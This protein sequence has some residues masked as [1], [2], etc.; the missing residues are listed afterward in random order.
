VSVLRK[1]IAA[2]GV[3]TAVGLG[4][5]TAIPAS[6][7]AAPAAGRSAVLARDQ[8]TGQAT[9]SGRDGGAVPMLGSIKEE[10]ASKKFPGMYWDRCSDGSTQWIYFEKGDT[11]C[12]FHWDGTEGAVWNFTE[13]SGPIGGTGTRT[14]YVCQINS[15]TGTTTM[16]NWDLAGKLHSLADPT[17]GDCAQGSRT[18]IWN[19]W[20]SWGG[21]NSMV[22]I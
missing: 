1:A 5:V 17:G 11:I 14:V 3:I 18:G 13:V 4:A 6:A 2:V 15:H 20:V 12:G 19:W 10:L 7:S 9:R 21:D 16:Y 8:L 22:A